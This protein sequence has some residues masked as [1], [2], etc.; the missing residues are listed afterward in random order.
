MKTQNGFGTVGVVVVVLALLLV[1]GGYYLATSNDQSN[2]LLLNSSPSPTSNEVTPS[3]TTP[4]AGEKV[5][6]GNPLSE[7]E[8]ES[9]D[10]EAK[11]PSQSEPKVTTP[12]NPALPPLQTKRLTDFPKTVKSGASVSDTGS[13]NTN[14]S[15]SIWD[16]LLSVA[17]AATS[18]RVFLYKSG[19]HPAQLFYYNLDT[20][21]K[22]RLTNDNKI[23]YSASILDQVNAVVYSIQ[24][25]APNFG[26]TLRVVSLDN[27]SLSK[28]IS[29][30]ALGPINFSLD[31]R[32]K[33]LAYFETGE[34]VVK[35]LSISLSVPSDV[36]E[37]MRVP[38]PSGVTNVAELAWTPDGQSVYMLKRPSGSG[39]ESII[40]FS[41]KEF[42]VREIVPADS[43]KSLLSVPFADNRL[44]HLSL[45]DLSNPSGIR[46]VET[47]TSS[48]VS[49][50][51]S[52]TAGATNYLVAPDGKKIY[53]HAAVNSENPIL[54]SR[55]IVG[56][57]RSSR[58]L[59]LSGFPQCAGADC[60]QKF[61]TYD[62]ATKTET[63]VFST[64]F[65]RDTSGPSG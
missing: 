5:I 55:N 47:N 52:E 12:S 30:N 57:G 24:N 50:K 48:G 10:Q 22:T 51:H 26:V 11:P 7:N 54:A 6:N 37:I 31:P 13:I 58:E 36:P 42:S 14:P 16:K 21:E 63:E 56:F 3:E 43:Y 41:L 39:P 32:G 64:Q 18:N 9:E 46:V 45:P 34:L 28:T 17:Y 62:T 61:Y 27:P 49:K 33:Y 15:A 4:L 1:G 23:I 60:V 65:E 35:D 59:I 29:T 44:F 38:L 8:E 19:S 53:F 25:S 20:R 2:D 40:A